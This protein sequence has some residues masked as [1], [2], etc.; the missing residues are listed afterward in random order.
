[1]LTRLPSLMELLMDRNSCERLSRFGIQLRTRG[2]SRL[3]SSTVFS[4]LQ[5][6][7]TSPQSSTMSTA[8]DSEYTVIIANDGF[9]YVCKKKILIEGSKYFKSML[10]SSGKCYLRGGSSYRLSILM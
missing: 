2:T 9:E 6:Y 5:R 10:E 1:R 3:P 8:Q 7:Q 4:F